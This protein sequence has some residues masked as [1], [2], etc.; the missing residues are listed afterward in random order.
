MM[1]HVNDEH[2][3]SAL[4]PADSDVSMLDLACGTFLQSVST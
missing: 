2:I 1:K 3:P 4:I